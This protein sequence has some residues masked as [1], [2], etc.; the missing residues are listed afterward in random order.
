MSFGYQ[1]EQWPQQDLLDGFIAAIGA[2][3]T[4]KARFNK[5]M[6]D[7]WANIGK[8]E[9]TIGGFNIP[10][11]WTPADDTVPL[12]LGATAS[13]HHALLAGKTGSGKSNLLH[14]MIHSLCEK[15]A[16][17]EVDLYLLDYKESTEFN[18]YATPPR[19]HARLVATE[20]D[21]EYGVTVLQHLVG[22][23]EGR[24]RIFKTAGVRD[25]AE[26]RNASR[27]QLPRVLLVI[28]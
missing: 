11:G 18:V 23:L 17:G 6:P 27:K 13:E 4:A 15:Y 8:G 21:P 26:Y 2:S 20:S 5:S 12:V 22:E 3:Y 24:A 7:L 25:F 1:M 14:V 9:T 28:D 19:P 10:I 16:P